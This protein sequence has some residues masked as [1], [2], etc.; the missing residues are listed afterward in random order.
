MFG[1]PDICS[2]HRT[3]SPESRSRFSGSRAGTIATALRLRLL[4]GRCPRRGGIGRCGSRPNP[5]DARLNRGEGRAPLRGLAPDAHLLRLLVLDALPKRL[6]PDRLLGGRPR[7]DRESQ[8]DQKGCRVVN[9][10]PLTPFLAGGVKR[11]PCRPV[12]GSGRSIPRRQRC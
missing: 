6:L 11:R 10:A 9:D 5:D 2:Y 4:S 7:S 12:P 3:Y 8:R 1:V